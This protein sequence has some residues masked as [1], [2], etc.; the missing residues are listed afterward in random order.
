MSEPE[1]IVETRG[2]VGL[3]TLNRPQALN[4]LTHGMVR[5]IAAALDRWERDAAIG[6]VVVRGAGE[7]AFCA[8]GDIRQLYERGKAGDVGFGLAFWADEYRLN[9]RIKTYP[10][11]YVALIDGIVMGGGVGVSEHGSLRVAGDRF[12]FAMPEVG[13][14]FFP[15]VGATHFLPRLPG[16]VGT[17]LALTGERV[18]G[19]DAVALGLADVH[20]PSAAMETLLAALAAGE[21][22][23]AAARRLATPSHPQLTDADRGVI[24]GCFEG[25]TVAE[26]LAGLDSSA[27][28]GS[29]FAAKQAATMRTKSPTSLAIALRQMQIGGG[30]DFAEA[31][32]T[33]YRIVSR[34]ARGRDF[35][36]GVRAVIVDK[37]NAPRWSPAAIGDVSAAMVDA[38]FAPLG[39][40]ELKLPAA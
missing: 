7:K 25:H 4:A 17:W 33:E 40:D 11:P 39:D 23:E 9:L 34:V 15:D 2:R 38:Y 16:K 32:R 13:I 1:V 12:Q 10:K 37:D 20:A 30:L 22:P 21:A 18:R 28:H 14:G 19:P 35:Y 27:A 31:M 24:D 6:C 8:G 3:L 36:E 26:I 29:A 5:D